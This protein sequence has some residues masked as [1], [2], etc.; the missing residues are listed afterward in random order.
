MG[1]RLSVSLGEVHR[2]NW[3][4][5]EDVT[6]LIHKDGEHVA[7]VRYEFVEG[8]GEGE[9]VNAAKQ[10]GTVRCEADS[11]TC[12]GDPIYVAA[13]ALRAAYAQCIT[14]DVE[15]LADVFDIHPSIFFEV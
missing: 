12:P 5:P 1:V 8:E 15:F 9:G 7:T 6:L 13:L 2:S 14:D 4:A 3:G 10:V 11:D